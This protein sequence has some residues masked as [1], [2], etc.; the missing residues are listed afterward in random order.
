MKFNKTAL[1]LAAILALVSCTKD[2]N[3]LLQGKLTF[4][5]EGDY[6]VADTKSKV[7]DFTALPG[8]ADFTLTIK[9]SEGKTFWTG[10][11]TEWS[12]ETQIP[13]GNYTASAEYGAEGTEGFGKPWFVGSKSF[14]VSGAKQTDVVIPI[15]LGNTIVR[16]STTAMFDNYFTDY[17]FTLV[18]GN[19]SKID[20]VKGENRAAFVDAF[21]FRV[22]GTLTTQGGSIVTFAGDEYPSIEEKTCYTISFDAPNAGGAT[23]NVSF[24]D[25][26]ETVSLGEL[27]LN[28]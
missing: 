8:K 11:L 26:L 28:D 12:S 25:T 3:A 7:S 2:K 24:N 4:D 22:N 10:K 16:I 20:F 17:T 1:W 14:A 5:V 15:A 18:T 23:V 9:D 13:S 19:G 6:M 27:E 21:R